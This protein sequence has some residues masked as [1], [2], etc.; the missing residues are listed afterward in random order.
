[1][2]NFARTHDLLFRGHTLVWHIS[3]P[4]WFEDT[5]NSRNAEQ[6]LVKHIETVVRHYA[7]QMHSWDVVNEVIAT[8]EGRPDGLQNT[9]WLKF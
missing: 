7:G 9:P 3:L 5:V 4:S 8:Y 6:F 1:M 2:A